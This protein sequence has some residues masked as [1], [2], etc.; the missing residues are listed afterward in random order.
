MMHAP[1]TIYSGTD[2]RRQ[3]NARINGSKTLAEE[4][5]WLKSLNVHLLYFVGAAKTGELRYKVNV[6]HAKSIFSFACPRYDCHEGGFELGAAVAAAA[7]GRRKMTEGEIRCEGWFG[8]HGHEKAS[9]K[10]L[11]RYTLRLGYV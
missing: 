11:M 2:F 3:L 10:T 1:Q 5:P 8:K 4:F 7:N 9:C 6:Q